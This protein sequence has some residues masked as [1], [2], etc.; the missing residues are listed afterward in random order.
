MMNEGQSSAFRALCAF[1]GE[2]LAPAPLVADLFAS[3]MRETQDA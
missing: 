3:G 2:K 1:R